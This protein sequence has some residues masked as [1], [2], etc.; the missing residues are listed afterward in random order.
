MNIITHAL[1]GWCAGL[2]LS[3]QL[4]DVAIVATASV[5]ADIDGLGAVVDVV[6]GGEAEIFSQYHHKFAH[7]LPFCLI[8]LL[9]IHLLRKN[10]RLTL[11]CAGVFH[12]HLLCDI[13]GARGP[14]GYQ[15]PV[16]YLF[17][18]LDSGIVW[19]YQWEI[20]AWPNI[21][22]TIVLIYLFLRQSALAG[23]TPLSL[24]APSADAQLVK[25]LQGRFQSGKTAQPVAVPEQSD[26]ELPQ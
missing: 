24:L 13:V 19:A 11:W 26:R 6:N 14:D 9:V 7:C 1:I 4:K 8:L 2:Q 18:F 23:F 22:L 12:L 16:Y 20:N 17:P 25:T 3:R 15:W 5:I 21:A 10:S